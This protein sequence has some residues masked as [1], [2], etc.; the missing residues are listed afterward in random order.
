[1]YRQNI[2]KVKLNIIRKRFIQGTLQIANTAIDLKVSRSTVTKYSE[3]YKIIKK[4]FPEKLHDMNFYMPNEPKSHR[5]SPVYNE[6]IHL[7]P[8]LVAIAGGR[9]LKAM[10][11]WHI[12]KKICPQGY[13]YSPFKI[14]FQKWV[15]E[16][17][18]EH[19]VPWIKPLGEEDVKL[20]NEW[21]TS[22]GHR[23]WQLVIFIEQALKGASLELIRHKA[24]T[25][26][27]TVRRWMAKYDLDGLTGLVIA[28]RKQ[29][30]VIKKRVQS[31]KARIVKLLH[32]SPKQ[33]QVNRAS[34]SIQAITQVY[35]KLYED[36]RC[37]YMSINR[38]I[39]LLGFGFKKSRDMLIS[40][41]PDY[42]IKVQN[43]QDILQQ[44][45]STEKFFSIDEFGPTSVRLKGG[46]TLQHHSAKPKEVPLEQKSKGYII[47]TAALEL[48]TNQITHFY[49]WKKNTT[50]MIKLLNILSIQ[51]KDQERLYISW[52]AAS[53]HNSTALTDHLRDCNSLDYRKQHQTPE[54]QLVPLPSCTQYLNVI[55]SVFSGL[56][57]AVIHNSDYQSMDECRQAIDLHFKARN[58]HF[59]DNPKRAGQKIWGKE[60]VAPQFSETH[61]TR[62]P[63]GTREIGSLK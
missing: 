40:P 19:P 27:A 48:S 55:E 49:S 36:D 17:V 34:W 52:D 20:L 29:N 50:E 2:P 18:T 54:L 3:R 12:Y 38:T 63:F 39:H 16:N 8:L 15:P 22:P 53:W 45:K 7:L 59:K 43:I 28:P 23:E 35:H 14:I 6:L 44:L 57:K 21:R 24:D 42:R 11:V 25:D 62:K 32:E 26:A 51:Y 33:Y 56:A 4:H 37:N 1:M 13:T 30:P 46:R 31:R 10:P 60:I 58:Q 47:C 9:S 5:P 61:H 41:D